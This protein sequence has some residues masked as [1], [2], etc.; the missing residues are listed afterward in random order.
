[1]VHFA[2]AHRQNAY[3]IVALSQPTH[4]KHQ[5]DAGGVVREHAPIHVALIRGEVGGRRAAAHNHVGSH[6]FPGKM[7]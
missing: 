7:T 6:L 3:V 1:M 5:R 2:G 4:T